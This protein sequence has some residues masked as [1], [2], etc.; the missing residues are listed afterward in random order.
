MKTL[1]KLLMLLTLGAVICLPG[2]ALAYT[3]NTGTLQTSYNPN[4]VY[5]F[6]DGTA[7][8]TIQHFLP[9]SWTISEETPSEIILTGPNIGIGQVFFDLTFTSASLPMS[10]QWAE[11][12]WAS[13]HQNYTLLGSGSLFYSGSGLT[14]PTTDNGVDPTFTHQSNI[15]L[16]PTVLLL[17]TGLLGLIGLGR[18]SRRGTRHDFR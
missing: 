2:M 12:L 18:K 9:A 5:L 6:M 10:C 4:A 7:T 13:D 1:V 8:M 11:V 3:F 14:I 15:P 16:P 17:G